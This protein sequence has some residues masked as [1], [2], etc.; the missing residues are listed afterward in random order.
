LIQSEPLLKP[1]I[2]EKPQPS[3]YVYYDEWTGEIIQITNKPRTSD[4]PYIKTQDS[5]AS[6]LM[7][8]IL[9]I[10]KYQVAELV[11]GL[12]LLPK[13]NVVRI[14]EAENILSKIRKVKYDVES[15]INIIMYINDYKME[16]NFSQDTLYKMTGKRFNKNTSINPEKGEYDTMELYVIRHNDPTFLID[17][18]EIDP[19]DLMTN[20]YKIYDLSHLRTICGLGD[21]DILTKRIF[22]SYG[23]K[24]RHYYTGSDYHRRKSQRRTH[25]KIQT[26]EQF[27][28]FSISPSNQGWIIKSNFDDP[29][30]YKLYR[31]LTLFI[32]A[33]DPTYLLQKIH[34]P[35]ANL[36]NRQEF[37][38]NT[39]LDI[40]NSRILLGE[41]AKNI[42]F[43]L[44]EI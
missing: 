13:D 28:A 2:E 12:K 26:G 43:R 22:K 10:S 30:E 5:N 11:D 7:M 23:V 27:A 44:E 17:T 3:F 34:I 18:I 19:L 37:V 33:D 42:T 39:Q 15:D 24:Y 6:K 25:K 31:D 14:R 16:V 1:A 38:V 40:H 8:G 32:T 20:G 9:S 36:G 29:A 41:H 4:Y 35:L 21:I